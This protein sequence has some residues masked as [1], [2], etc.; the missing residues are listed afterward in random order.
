MN[1]EQVMEYLQQL[2][3]SVDS[4]IH[5]ILHALKHRAVEGSNEEEAKNIWCIEQVYKI[6]NSYISAFNMMKAGKFTEAWN[7]FDRSDIEL[8]FLRKHFDYNNNEYKLKFIEEK[9]QL[10]QKLFPYN[11][12]FSREAIE[13]DFTCSICGSKMGLRSGCSHKVGEIYQGEMC[14]R[15]VNNIEFIGMAIVSDPFDKYTVPIIEG[16]SYNYYMLENL[17]THLESPFDDWNLEIIEEKWSYKDDDKYKNVGRNDICPC[18]SGKKFKHCCYQKYGQ[19]IQH[20]KITL[21]KSQEELKNFK[22]LP[23]TLF[24]TKVK[25]T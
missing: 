25:V 10:F 12:F 4:N 24:R 9:I 2:E 3:Q 22:N 23:R 19:T 8:S 7:L 17:L 1:L 13:S 18:Q 21:L 16:V 6:L 15:V 14:G 5:N 11:I 20:H